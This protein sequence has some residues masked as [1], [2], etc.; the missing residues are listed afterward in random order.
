MSNHVNKFDLIVTSE[1]EEEKKKT[2]KNMNDLT[3]TRDDDISRKFTR[4][5][6]YLKLING[7]SNQT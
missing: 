5:H 6:V 1:K 3:T 7:K 2:K 4:L